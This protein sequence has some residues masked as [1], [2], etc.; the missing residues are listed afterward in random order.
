MCAME[1][2]VKFKHTCTKS[3][4]EFLFLL[5]TLVTTNE[6]LSIQIQIQTFLLL[7]IS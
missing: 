7:N 3:L 4:T 5:M 2:K 6:Y 1:N